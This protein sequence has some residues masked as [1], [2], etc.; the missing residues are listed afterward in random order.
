MTDTPSL[1]YVIHPAI[2][3]ARMGNAALDLNDD[4]TFYIGP[5]APYQVANSQSGDP[6]YKKDGKI[7]KQAQRFRIYEYENGQARRE[8]TLQEADIAAIT[9]TVHLGNRKAALDTAE[10]SQG[11]IASPT[12]WPRDFTPAITRNA[13]VPLAQRGDLSIDAGA[14]E[15][16]ADGS[17]KSLGGK[18]TLHPE[19]AAT[20]TA[21]ITLGAVASEVGTGRLLVFAGDGL[22]KGVKDGEFSENAPI[23]NEAHI[24]PW[25]N[26]DNWY[27]ESADGRVMAEITFASGQKVSLSSPEQ[28]AW[29][30]CSVPRY[31]PGLNYF[32]NLHDVALNAARPSGGDDPAPSF[33]RD[34]FP[35]LI[36]VSRLQWVSAKGAEGHGLSK[37]GFFLASDKL[38]YLADDDS[39][40]N[41]VAYKM[42][43]SVFAR[44]RDP[45]ELPV[46][47][48]NKLTREQIKPKQM[49]QLPDEV[50]ERPGKEDWDI[51]AVTP[52]QYA[53]M[54]KWRDGD[55]IAD[56]TGDLPEYVPLEQIDISDQPEALDRAALSGTA[57]T[58]FYPGIESWNIMEVSDMYA[59][60]LRLKSNV[61]PG[62]L[63]MGNALPWQ[64][65][66]LD[67]TDTWW[68]VQRPGQVT[69]DG[70]PLQS[71]V[72]GD[73]DEFSENPKYNEMVKHWWE[74]GFVISTNGGASY[75]E[76]ERDI[77]ETER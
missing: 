24:D 23:G 15:V 60:P 27:D 43:Q 73:W 41:S 16:P 46:R 58:P 74:L 21:D 32:T 31:V 50:I 69:R 20:M 77:E 26:S 72:P 40:P 47:P 49:P 30:I 14:S 34:I 65:D 36:N 7:K 39:D 42:R 10:A 55:F 64:A 63:S 2:G 3:V 33:M 71:W 6:T 53:M 5:E 35:M 22:S 61:Q 67:C 9:W 25:A 8:V 18:I 38:K 17:L 11:T 52:L 51:A 59:A 29:V 1:S 70:K 44:M 66:F 13:W 28:S 75:H 4:S 56:F 19:N 68:P 45:N 37:P 62:D 76:T 57:G 12:Y 54:K 48:Y